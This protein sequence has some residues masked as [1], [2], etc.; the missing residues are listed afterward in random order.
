MAGNAMSGDA[1]WSFSVNSAPTV[2]SITPGNGATITDRTPTIAA[3]VRDAQTDL[4]KANI[5][6]VVDGATIG[7]TAYSYDR[8]TDRLS[9]TSS[10]A[11]GKHT[12]RITAKDAQG[13]V[14]T[15]S[16]YFYVK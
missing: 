6:L 15:R 1:A 13:L 3:T 9:Y 8:A 12:V 16:W 4:A 5:T 10:R 14:Y 7:A 2:A 11:V